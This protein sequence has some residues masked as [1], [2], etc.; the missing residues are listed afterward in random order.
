[1][2]YTYGLEENEEFKKFLAMKPE[3]FDEYMCKTYPKMFNQRRLP[4]TQTC[5][6]WGFCISKGWYYH[7]DELCKKLEIIRRLTDVRVSFVQIKEKYGSGR[8][9]HDIRY[10]FS[11]WYSVPSKYKIVNFIKKVGCNI[12]N[13]LFYRMSKENLD[14]I[15]DIIEELV[16][17]CEENVG[18]VCKETGKHIDKPIEWGWIYPLSEEGFLKAY[19]DRE[20]AL[21][22]WKEYEE[23]KELINKAISKLDDKGTEELKKFLKIS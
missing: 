16:A 12:I 10:G 6:C 13:K 5:M 15:A 19:P 9:Y 3:E 21:K 11:T 20:D 18:Y 7:L 2:R 14:I 23:E 22:A 4:M 8:F 17:N 1:M